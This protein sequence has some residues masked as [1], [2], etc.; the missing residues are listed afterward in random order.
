MTAIGNK[1]ANIVQFNSENP[2]PHSWIVK[3][4]KETL[5]KLYPKYSA[6]DNDGFIYN[7]YHLNLVGDN[8]DSDSDS[9]CNFS[10]SR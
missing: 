10:H 7:I 4:G 8:N 9:E 3:G 5:E 6:S 2:Y 1:G